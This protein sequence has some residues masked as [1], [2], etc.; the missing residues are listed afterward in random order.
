MRGSGTWRESNR[1]RKDDGDGDGER[2]AGSASAPP[3]GL[4]EGHRSTC[5]KKRDC[6]TVGPRRGS[7]ASMTLHWRRNSYEGRE[8]RLA[9]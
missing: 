4:Q 9:R 1:Y 5:L 8:L 2:K 7:P 6:E 3:H